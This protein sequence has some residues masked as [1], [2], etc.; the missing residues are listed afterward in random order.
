[1]SAYTLKILEIFVLPL[2]IL[3][4]VV[5]LTVWFR[6]QK[7]RGIVVLL[8]I[9]TTLIAFGISLEYKKLTAQELNMRTSP[10]QQVGRMAE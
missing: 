9:L 7:D 2:F 5:G 6:Q 10:T 3:A 8:F 1:M 4:S